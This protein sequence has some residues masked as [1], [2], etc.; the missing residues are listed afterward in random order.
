M[1]NE[2]CIKY[3]GPEYGDYCSS[4]PPAQFNLF[5]TI[6]GFFGLIVGNIPWVVLLIVILILIGK[7]FKIILEKEAGVVERLGRYNRT[8][9]SGFRV[10]IPFFEKIVYRVNLELMDIRTDSVVK[11]KEDQ[12][13]KLPLVITYR[14]IQEEAQKAFYE[15]DKPKRVIQAMVGNEIKAVVATM[16]LQEL[17]NDRDTIK[18]TVI[19]KLADT[20][21][22]YGFELT[23]VVI[24]DPVLSKAMQNALNNVAIA[25]KT[26][27]AA[28]AEGEALKIQEIAQAEAEAA[29]LKIKTGAYVESRDMMARGNAVA[30]KELIGDTDLTAAQ[31][32]GFLA[33]IDRLDAIRDAAEAGA[34]VVI[35]S[36][37]PTGATFGMIAASTN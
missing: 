27:E 22:S 37:N 17:Y 1:N 14:A 15:V 7:A 18:R 33:N 21:A 4:Y 29:S 16:T 20:F 2:D 3:Y 28:Q 35:D 10:I 32:L 23:N 8:L 6:G 9:Q 24:D 19:E 26:K 11:T 30:L 34:T 25:M 36:N 13:V 12:I 31:G 5:D